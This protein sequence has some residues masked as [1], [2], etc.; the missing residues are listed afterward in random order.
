[1][2]QSDWGKSPQCSLL[3]FLPVTQEFSFFEET[4]KIC[5]VSAV[6][7]AEARMGLNILGFILGSHLR[8]EMGRKLGEVWHWDAVVL[9]RPGERE[10]RSTESPE[11]MPS[12]EGSGGP[13]GK[14]DH[15]SRCQSSF[16]SPRRE[17]CLKCPCLTESSQ[18]E[19]PSWHPGDWISPAQQLEPLCTV[20]T[21][22]QGYSVSFHNL[23]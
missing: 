16:L 12:K 10:G 20:V 1:M 9:Q 3:S 2:I 17:V 13:Q 6:W 18:W 4:V 7:E 21:A 15:Q 8:R 5:F 19:A 23:S 11:T 22:R 14:Y